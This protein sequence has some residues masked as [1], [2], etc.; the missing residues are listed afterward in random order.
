MKIIKNI[1][2]EDSLQT[3]GSAKVIKGEVYEA[4]TEAREIVEAARTEAASIRAKA[5]DDRL[6]AME[7]GV[8][9]GYEEGLKRWNQILAETRQRQENLKV[10]WEQSLLRLSVRIAEKIVG[11]QL[12]VKP[13]TILTIIQEALKNVGQERQLTLVV[14]PQHTEMVQAHMSRLEKTIGPTRQIHL[15][16]NP[17]MAPGGCMVES[18]LGV[19]DARL[20]VQLR[21]LEEV[22]LAK[23]GNSQSTSENSK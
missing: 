18:E 13:E 12:Q 17:E 3:Q 11:E 9:I 4:T 21:C 15:V 22:L 5:E 1:P 23:R 16:S 10:E 7:S 6:S 8:Q 14:H 19:I 2:V 20:D